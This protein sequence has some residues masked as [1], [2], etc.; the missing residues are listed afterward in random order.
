[1][2]DLIVIAGCLVMWPVNSKQFLRK[3]AL[4]FCMGIALSQLAPP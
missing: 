2:I 1:M 3:V 4:L